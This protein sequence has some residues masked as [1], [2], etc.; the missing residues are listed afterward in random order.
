MSGTVA[1]CAQDSWIFSG[2][3]QDNVIFGRKFSEVRY[4][5]ALEA[6]ALLNDVSQFP[7]GDQTLVGDRG[8]SLSGYLIKY[9]DRK[10]VLGGQKARVA[11]AR[12]IYADADIYFLDDPLSAVDAAVGR[13]LFD[14]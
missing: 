4:K 2:T 8:T 14:K 6:S 10:R 5:N 7:Q 13:F 12:A 1:Y 3:V 11:L 9:V